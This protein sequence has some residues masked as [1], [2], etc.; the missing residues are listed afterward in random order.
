[1]KTIK[2]FFEVYKPKAKDEQEF[3]DKHVTVKHKDRNGNDDDVF[4]AK[5]V[6]Y[7]KRK[8]ERHGYDAG[9]D[10]KV[11]EEAEEID[12]LSRATVGRYS[13]KA[14]SIAD[15][16]GGKDRSKG[17]ELAGRKKWGGTMSGVEKARVMATEEIENFDESY[18]E[19]KRLKGNIERNQKKMK[20]IPGIHPDK[21][22]LATQIERDTKKHKELFD[23]YWSKNEEYELD[24]ARPVNN[25]EYEEREKAWNK[26]KADFDKNQKDGKYMPPKK[27]NEDVDLAFF[28]DLLEMNLDEDTFTDASI[29]NLRVMK[30]K[31]MM[32]DIEKSSKK[33]PLMKVRLMSDARKKLAE[34][35][36]ARD[37]YVAK[38]EKAQSKKK[39][40][41]EEV[42]DIE[43]GL[44]HDRYLRSHG[45]KAR[46]A[47]HWAF[48]T[49]HMGDPSK[50]EMTFA[51]GKLA[52]AHKEAAK[53]LGT[54]RLYVMEEI[55]LDEKTLTA[56]EKK[57]REEIAKAM[58]RENPDMPMAQKM[59]IATA[60]AK[61]VAE[62]SDAYGK[63]QDDIKKKNITDSDKGKIA[64]LAAMMSKEKK[65]VNEESEQI[66][67]LSRKTLGSYVKRAADQKD[68]LKRDAEAAS[69]IG[70]DMRK[71]DNNEAGAQ[72]MFQHAGKQIRKSVN[73]S[74]GLNRAV[75]KL[76][77]EEAEDLDELSKDTLSRYA[78]RALND[79]R[80]ANQAKIRWASK[81]NQK[82]EI[83][84]RDPSGKYVRK[85]PEDMVAHHERVAKNREKG[86][87]RAISR[88]T[89]ED[90]INRTIEKYMPE[91]YTP[92]SLEE[93]LLAKIE[94]L[95]EAHA[96]TLLA[97]FDS[98]NEDNKSTMLD[99]VETE[100]GINGLLDFA[101]QNRGE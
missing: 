55:D 23:K 58:E 51:S 35:E 6:K 78:N 85:T 48:T 3:V 73:R 12:E 72:K 45:K 88:M 53:K 77:K 36:K 100:E 39:K 4:N 7:N 64:S 8:E 44:M 84:V 63:S 83:D 41:T 62:S 19:L 18:E 56:A 89:K 80:N 60:Q 96:V 17:R 34:L 38:H 27:T 31:Q 30:H 54:K 98:L 50:D 52:D 92:P 42:E 21:K 29:A 75:D 91:D 65:P 93:Q 57:K 15:N 81:E 11:Y 71:L 26:Q 74:I 66:D 33:H 101:I 67:E 10:E 43:E 87:R 1:M 61:K 16:E 90:I 70:H 59:A 82:R 22:R 14:K 20:S 2:Q 69:Q 94:H 40:V 49:K 99:T 24:E 97:L 25:P 5:N 79:V 9:E 37:H 32:K 46:G 68:K 13:M 47:G 28:E 86:V 76:T 95:P